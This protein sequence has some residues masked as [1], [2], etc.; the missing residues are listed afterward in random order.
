MKALIILAALLAP[1]GAIAT[2]PA[3]AAAA[4][5]M[6][7]PVFE[8]FKIV[9]GRLDAFMHGVTMWD[10]VSVA[11][12]QPKSQVYLRIGGKGDVYDVMLYKEPRLPT[13]PA[14]EAA[15]AAKVKELGL[16]TGEAF[17]KELRQNMTGTGSRLDMEGPLDAAEWEARKGK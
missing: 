17:Y 10:I 5:Q 1:A 4:G 12:G 8:L 2:E 14:Q 13:T 16:A 15:M 9:P 6:S 11:G 3:P 7:P